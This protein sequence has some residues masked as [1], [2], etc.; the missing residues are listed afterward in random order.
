SEIQAAVKDRKGSVQSPKQV[1]VVDSLPM[2][3][4]GKPDKKALRAKFW[5]D[6]DRAVG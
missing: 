3:A 2:T 6:A 4:L 1:V 5:E